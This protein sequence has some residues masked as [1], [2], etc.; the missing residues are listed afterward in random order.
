[1]VAFI[2][3]GTGSGAA[4]EIAAV[5]RVRVP[6]VPMGLGVSSCLL[7][8][9]GTLCL[10]SDIFSKEESHDNIFDSISLR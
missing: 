10:R 6:L 3:S 2:G 1:V 7:V 8:S 5:T 4:D 9:P